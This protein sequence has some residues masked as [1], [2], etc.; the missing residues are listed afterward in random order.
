M[1]VIVFASILLATFVGT[2]CDEVSPDIVPVEGGLSG[3]GHTTRYWDCCKP[4][5]AWK[6]NIKTPTMVPVD[7]CAKDGETV[8]SPSIQSG[9]A[10]GTSY[11][12]SNQQATVINSTLAYGFAAG[13]FTGGVDYNYCCACMLLSFQ[14]QLAGKQLLV[15]I[16]NTG[17]DL[18]SN[19][20][21]LA[22]PGGG[23]GIFTQGCHD[24]WNAPWSGWG[25]QY[26]GVSSAEQCGELPESLQPGCRFRFEFL[27][28]AD[29][30]AVKFQQVKCPAE[31]VAISK[32][33]L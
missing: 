31:L 24:Q 18:G 17:G 19:Q 13:S 9:C 3:D 20:F 16:T 10:G 32:C 4:S 33:D 2:S 30:P 14:G 6:E 8:V 11:M 5:C 27:E 28:N 21:D 25:D 12:C 26:G 1:Q 7:T 23:V 29:N 15:Q 22:L